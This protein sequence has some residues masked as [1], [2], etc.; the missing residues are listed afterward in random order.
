MAESQPSSCALHSVSAHIAHLLRRVPVSPELASEVAID[1]V[2][3]VDVSGVDVP[4]DGAV[5]DAALVV[6]TLVSA[7]FEVVEA[8]VIS[9]V[10]PEVAASGS[11]GGSAAQAP[12]APSHPTNANL[13]TEPR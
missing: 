4:S 3:A 7:A 12:Q 13:L 6:P 5:V 1:D 2:V 8:V 10:E 11:S 9:A